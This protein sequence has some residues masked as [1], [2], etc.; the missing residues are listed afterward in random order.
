MGW[1]GAM[2]SAA[3][4]QRRSQRQ[5]ERQ[6]SQITRLADG[7]DREMEKFDAEQRRDLAKMAEAE[8]RMTERPLSAGGLT[9]DRSRGVWSFKEIADRTGACTWS[10]VMELT[11][12]QDHFIG[13]AVVNGARSYRAIALAFSRWGTFVAF[14]VAACSSVGKPRKLFT[15]SDPTKNRLFLRCGAT[16]HQAIEGD[17]DRDLI[18]AGVVIAAFPALALSSFSDPVRIEFHLTD[19]PTVIDVP[20]DGLVDKLHRALDRQSLVDWLAEEY[21]K[22]LAP[23][24]AKAAATKAD[25][26]QAAERA[27]AG[28]LVFLVVTAAMA[29]AGCAALAS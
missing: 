13:D 12:A 7:I 14:E 27:K 25:L 15:K 26:A 18:G 2:R 16:L 17:L 10:L 28:C 6:V 1:R 5:S 4:A 3:A 21:R 11:S 8:Q 24:R 23:V 20:V 19:T 9:F 29:A 22:K